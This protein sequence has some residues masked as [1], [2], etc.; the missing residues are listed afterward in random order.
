[1]NLLRNIKKIG[2][3][4]TPSLS[5]DLTRFW[6]NCGVNS[7]NNPACFSAF[8]LAE[9]MVVMLI[10]S[11][12]LAA[13]APVMTTR[14]KPNNSSPWQYEANN[15]NNAW[16]G[17]GAAQEAMIGQRQKRTG[18]IATKLQITLGSG[19]TTT[20]LLA[21][22]RGDTQLGRL[23]IGNSNNLLLGLMPT[24]ATLGS[25]ANA[26][27]QNVEATGSY[28]TA[29]GSVAKANG[30]NSTAVGATVTASGANSIAIGS[31][32]TASADSSVAI[33]QSTTA[34]NYSSSILSTGAVAIGSGAKAKAEKAIAIGQN[35]TV[36]NYSDSVLSTGA[37][38]IGSTN[39]V[40]NG[41][42][43]IAIGYNV[44]A[45]GKNGTDTGE[46]VIA[47]GKGASAIGNH[48]LAIGANA[49]AQGYSNKY[50]SSSG[51]LYGDY[52]S[53]WG[54]SSIAIGAGAN[55]LVNKP[56]SGTSG[57]GYKNSYIVDTIAIGN[58]AQANA[59]N[60]T[61]LGMNAK[62]DSNSRGSIAIGA[63]ANASTSYNNEAMGD[64]IA[65]GT[66]SVASGA[67]SVAIGSGLGG[68]SSSGT[69]YTSASGRNSIAI[70][71]EAKA[72]GDYNIAI[73]YA[74]CSNVTGSNKVCIGYGAGPASGSDWAKDDVE[75]VFIGGKSNFNGGS[76]VL[77][78]HNTTVS[79]YVNHNNRKANASAVVINGNLIVK[80]GIYAPVNV[81]GTNAQNPTGIAKIGLINGN[82]DGDDHWRLSAGSNSR[83]GANWTDDLDMFYGQDVYGNYK[84]LNA[85]GKVSSR[86]SDRRLKYVGKENTSGLDKI[87]QLKI[88]NYTYK[89]DTTK[90]PHVGVIAQDLQKVFPNAVKK[91]A[92]GFLTIRMEDMF[93]AVINA[94][95]ELDAKYQAQE[96]RITALEQENKEFKARLERLEA[97]T[98]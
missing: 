51:S 73:G 10:L 59:A 56:M 74:A 67:G 62:V 66:Y 53:D 97:K 26:V 48:A 12:V 46:S 14:N 19:D 7:K 40:V 52:N 70:G 47:I 45:Q 17:A 61:A 27:G 75:R 88:F 77:E 96:K 41:D 43:T 63:N 21:F 64:S 5:L 85:S 24:S 6:G 69:H 90:T 84:D 78:V 23:Y 16:F 25:N 65:L 50:N 18:D 32:T 98:K 35:T 72:G 95:K 39:N 28:S 20:S 86:V 36:Q 8:T 29:F 87:R 1:M 92:D 82:L 33:G 2:G 57:A 55:A 42:G 9:M 94:I 76:A 60:G 89:K 38:A 79:K 68:S 83:A 13:M 15:R 4:V 31:S 44:T 54:F 93:Y 37:I 80:G 11:I 49:Q 22:N 58:N 30:N 34:E 3:G 81:L 91:G 71:N